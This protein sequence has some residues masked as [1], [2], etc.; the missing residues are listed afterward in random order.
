MATSQQ[1]EASNAFTNELTH[2]NIQHK[3]LV[4]GN[5]DEISKKNFGSPEHGRQENYVDRMDCSRSCCCGCK[6]ENIKARK[7]G[8]KVCWKRLKTLII[9]L[10]V[11]SVASSVPL[12]KTYKALAD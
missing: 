3:E 5:N 10:R 12:H 8:G 4:D 6:L 7:S 9:L 2:K 1:L 11:S